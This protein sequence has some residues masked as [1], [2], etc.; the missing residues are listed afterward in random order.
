MYN[1]GS[2]TSSQATAA[3]TAV[4]RSRSGTCG[5]EKVLRKPGRTSEAKPPRLA[6]VAG[7]GAVTIGGGADVARGW[8]MT[9]TE[10]RCSSSV[11]SLDGGVVV[12]RRQDV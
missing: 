8:S 7:A 3:G 9:S 4:P 12:M 10:S 6:V 1:L 5:L 2:C 11:I